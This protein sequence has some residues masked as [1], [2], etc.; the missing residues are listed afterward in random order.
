MK[1]IRL[2][3]IIFSF[4]ISTNVFSREFIIFSV[5]H[6]IDMGGTTKKAPKNFFINIGKLQGVTKGS[7]LKVLR[8]TINK[9]E[10]ES[11]KE[12]QTYIPIG[13]VKIIHSDENSSIGI[14]D[15]L[16]SED[17][18]NFALYPRSFMIGDKVS[19]N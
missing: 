3:L 17:S 1:T 14:K 13:T 4:I 12:Y 7:R 19:I 11:G 2:T 18:G 5:E 6:S 9:N 10:F 16:Y 8:K 15:E